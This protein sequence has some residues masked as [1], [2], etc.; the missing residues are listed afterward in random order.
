MLLVADSIMLRK[1]EKSWIVGGKG[2]DLHFFRNT[3]G[4]DL[5]IHVSW[6]RYAVGIRKFFTCGNIWPFH[7]DVNKHILRFITLIYY[8]EKIRLKNSI[9]SLFYLSYRRKLQL[10]RRIFQTHSTKNSC[11]IS[12]FSIHDQI[13]KIYTHSFWRFNLQ[14][15]SLR[16]FWNMIV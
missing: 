9:F 16:F 8:L 3:I 13:N 15:K 5:I 10:S 14:N 11:T 12:K 6:I 2:I 1:H 4:H 7:K